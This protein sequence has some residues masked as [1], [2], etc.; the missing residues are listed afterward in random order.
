M[1]QGLGEEGG[2]Q[3][4]VPW[5]AVGRVLSGRREGVEL[6]GRVSAVPESLEGL[7]GVKSKGR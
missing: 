7:K 2:S 1:K 3:V 6:E 5:G 4:E